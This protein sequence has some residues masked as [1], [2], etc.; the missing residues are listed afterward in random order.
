MTD[1][2]HERLPPVDTTL[3]LAPSNSCSVLIP[4]PVI[5]AFPAM[6]C[7]QLPVV[8]DSVGCRLPYEFLRDLGS[9]DNKYWVEPA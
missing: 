5:C 8:I 3:C 6:L 2:A 9:N 1:C 4:A 7:P